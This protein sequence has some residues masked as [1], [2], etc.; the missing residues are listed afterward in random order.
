MHSPR[1][2]YRQKLLSWRGKQRRVEAQLRGEPNTLTASPRGTHV[3]IKALDGSSA[4]TAE[5]T[6]SINCDE[7]R[8]DV[9]AAAPGVVDGADCRSEPRELLPRDAQ[10]VLFRGG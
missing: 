4:P 2:S 10:A 5:P 9:R 8:I 7:N 3:F 1:N 6:A